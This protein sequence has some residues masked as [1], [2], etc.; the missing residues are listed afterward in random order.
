MPIDRPLTPA[1]P[2]P[3]HPRLAFVG[4]GAVGTTLA[5]AFAAAGLPVTALYRR[6]TGK[7]WDALARVPGATAAATPQAAAD[8]ADVV[9]LTVPD[10]DVRTTCAGIRWRPNQAVVHCSGATELDALQHAGDAGAAVGAF[11]PLQMFTPSPASLETL[12]GCTVTIDA[13]GALG[14]LLESL[15]GRLGCRAVRLPPGRRALYHA[16]AYYVGP[17]LIALMK[18]AAGM[19]SALGATEEDALAALLP[20]LQGT[21]A[22]VKARGLAGGMGG[23]VARGDVGTVERHLAALEGHSREAALLYRTL[24]LRTVPLALERGTLPPDGATRIRAA[25]APTN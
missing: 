8:V 17:F 11:H 2:P 12:P 3:A 15:A 5:Q 10:D 19:W 24:A 1:V 22:A 20:L 25:L 7:L 4:A 9:F 23:C 21:V 16:S 13:A 14:D 18:E 6:D